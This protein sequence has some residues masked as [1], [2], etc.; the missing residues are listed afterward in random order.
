[1]LKARLV[2]VF[3][4]ATM[5]VAGSEPGEVAV[6]FLNKVRSGEV[7]LEPGKDTALRASTAESKKESIR[8]YLDG[9]EWSLGK[10][11]LELSRVKV[12]GEY[13][14]A[15]VR[16]MD[17]FDDS[18][19]EVYAVAL[20]KEGENWLPAPVLASF[21]N[22]VVGYT[23]D[24]KKRLG[25]LEQWMMR[26]RVVDLEK[27]IGEREGILRDK[28]RGSIEG[29][30]L[31]GD[32]FAAIMDGFVE[33]CKERDQAAILAYLGGLSE[34]WPNDWRAI[35]LAVDRVVADRNHAVFPW[36]L[37]TAPE[38]I[39]FPARWDMTAKAGTFSY[40]CLDPGAV[41]EDE[42]MEGIFALHFDFKKD[43]KNLWYI[44][45]SDVFLKGEEDDA[46]EMDDDLHEILPRELRK[47]EKL[48]I[49]PSFEEAEKG[50]M[51]GMKRGELHG[52]F[53]YA[54]L[55]KGHSAQLR[56]CEA[57]ASFWWSMNKPG[58]YGMPVRLGGKQI[59][60]YAVVAFHWFS[61]GRPDQYDLKS[62]V[63]KKGE[64]GWVW[65]P[66]G[67]SGVN[68]ADRKALNEWISANDEEW[69]NG[70]KALVVAE[71]VELDDLT[72]GDGV[73]DE[74]V[75]GFIEGWLTKLKERDVAG[76]LSS[77]ACLRD[78]KGLPMRTFRSMF[79]DFGNAQRSEI[80]IMDIY[81]EGGWIAVGLEYLDGKKISRSFLPLAFTKKG[82][83]ILPEVDLITESKR[84][85]DFLHKGSFER[86]SKFTKAE[87]LEILK[88]MFAKFKEISEE[89]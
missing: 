12:D 3:G 67:V 82:M 38:V 33:A 83:R 39:R 30:L 49:F 23:V 46:Y 89:E 37:L 73:G 2:V 16:R 68:E 44:E 40:V 55:G 65:V 51:E 62:V 41:Q 74:E 58:V 11:E 64:A 78:Y 26:E 24:L 35:T 45:P 66:K 81:R 19:L 5:F 71:M 28:L 27:L 54:E 22:S 32:D 34:P 70:W 20:V 8:E 75:R 88:G 63:F 56:N 15:L 77:A 21:E 52:L 76:A 13:A 18:E 31:E 7:D 47:S 59:G 10:G 80:R 14:A 36:R 72:G 29:E 86:L 84:N 1:V 79:Y 48:E 57:V 43:A 50:L 42:E 60:D 25:G 9:M 69:E 4:L 53:R 17:D 61:I 87:D 6:D 85:R